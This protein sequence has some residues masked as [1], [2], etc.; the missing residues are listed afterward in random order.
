MSPSIDKENLEWELDT[1]I[2]QY[3]TFRVYGDQNEYQQ[4]VDS[5]GLEPIVFI[6]E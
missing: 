5:F 1:V 6:R 2:N 4:F 3:F